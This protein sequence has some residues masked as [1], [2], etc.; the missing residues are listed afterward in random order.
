MAHGTSPAVTLE[1]IIRKA[2]RVD[3]SGTSPAVLPITHKL[4]VV[5]S[6]YL[7]QTPYASGAPVWLTSSW[8][9]RWG[10]EHLH[11]RA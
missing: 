11:A 6:V 10:N 9:A 7:E 8:A 2:V 4:A 1:G 3:F 5:M